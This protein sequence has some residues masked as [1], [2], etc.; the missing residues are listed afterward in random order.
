MGEL[1][2]P[3][4]LIHGYL[5]FELANMHRLFH[6]P[7]DPDVFAVQDADVIKVHDVVFLPC[8]Y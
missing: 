1:I 6:P 2:A 3:I 4:V 7:A 5:R 8:V